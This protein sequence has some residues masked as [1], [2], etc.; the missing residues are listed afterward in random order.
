MAELVE[1]TDRI[2]PAIDRAISHL[3]KKLTHLDR[4]TE[5][6]STFDITDPMALWT[7]FL[8]RDL[9][10]SERQAEI[11]RFKQV[12]DRIA[13]FPPGLARQETRM[14]LVDAIRKGVYTRVTAMLDTLQY[15]LDRLQ[16]FRIIAK[17]SAAD[18][19][20]SFFR[21]GFI[22]LMTAFDMRAFDERERMRI[23]HTPH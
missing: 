4:P 20:I 19:F 23:R 5:A 3:N 22:L 12:V 14:L 16:Q 13:R 2:I 1:A 17:A 9:P 8:V 7:A 18:E 15:A 21:Q 6:D 10:Q 11:E